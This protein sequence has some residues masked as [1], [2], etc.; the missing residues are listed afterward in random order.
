MPRLLLV[1]MLLPALA[2]A[3]AISVDDYGFPLANPFEATI[4]TTPPALRAPLADPDDVDQADYR[5]NLR[6]E[7]EARLPS[8]FWPVRRLTY[9]LARQSG[10]APLVFLIA[11][12]GARYDASNMEALKGVLYAAGFHVAQVSSPTSY[13]FMSAASRLAT[14]GY[15]PEDAR[16]LYRV[17]L[18]IRDRHPELPVSDYLLVGYSLGGLQ[19]AF[20]SRLD[21]ERR[22]FGFRRV[23]MINP[24]VN[25][26]TS[27]RNLDRLVQVRLGDGEQANFYE[28]VL[29]RLSRYFRARGTIDL[30]E[31]MLLEFQQSP[32]QLNDEEMAMLVGSVFRLTAADIVFTSDLINRR[33][34]IVPPGQRIGIGTSLEPYFRLALQCNF[35]CYMTRQLIP[36]WRER[37]GGGSITQL[38]GQTSLYALE[39]YLRDSPKIAALHNADDIILGPGDLGF[40]R[41]ALGDRLTVFPRGGH[42]GNLIYHVNVRYMLEFLRG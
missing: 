42:C 8:S 39:Q 23:L 30:N 25:L 33:G 21:E 14:P 29:D 40:L 9:R 3:E 32:Y 18:A 11:G 10:T 22:Q 7:R 24:P 5:L 16:D 4:A 36:M 37:Q 6:P 2:A 26:D 28:R 38:A 31:A 19:A 15:S 13:D 35:E 12:T 17:M 20:V 27:V 34:L 1:L 41:R